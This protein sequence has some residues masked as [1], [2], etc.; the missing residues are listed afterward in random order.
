MAFW[1]AFSDAIWAANGV[2]LR[3]PLK[4]T[5]PAL[6]HVTTLPVPSVMVTMVLLKVAWMQAIPC[7]TPFP[8]F[9]LGRVEAGR[10]VGVAIRSSGSAGNPW[11]GHP[12]DD[13]CARRIAAGLGPLAGRRGLGRPLLP[14]GT[15]RPLPGARVG[16]GPLSPHRESPPV[17]QPPVAA[18]V[19]ESLDVHGHLALQI[20]LDPVAALDDPP[21]LVDLVLGEVLDADVLADLGLGQNLP[22]QGSA[23]PVDVRQGD[24][25]PLLPRQI[26]ARNSRHRKPPWRA[27]GA[28]RPSPGAVCAWGSR[29]PR[30]GPLSA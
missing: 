14:H 19:H 18:D 26:H 2:L 5:L 27:N 11:P 17:T 30:G 7:V 16:A 9:L 15:F 24:L 29:R 22:R 21:Q 23:D 12:P 10:F 20:A 6:A 13:G 8:S 1:A 25:Q 4:P 28:A 3:E